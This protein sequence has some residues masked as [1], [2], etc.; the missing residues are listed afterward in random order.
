MEGVHNHIVVL[1]AGPGPRFS[2]NTKQ[3]APNIPFSSKPKREV[4][5]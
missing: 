3:P 2:K 4:E 1:P 5:L